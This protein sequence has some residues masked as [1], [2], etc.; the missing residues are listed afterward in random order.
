MT[1]I[2]AVETPSWLRDEFVI[3]ETTVARR[4]VRMTAGAVAKGNEERTR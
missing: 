2:G 3:G 4:D 1:I